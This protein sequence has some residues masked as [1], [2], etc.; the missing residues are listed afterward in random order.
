M[1]YV[2]TRNRQRNYLALRVLEDSLG[3]DGGRFLPVVFPRYPPERICALRGRS[4]G[5]ILAEILGCFF[6]AGVEAR[7]VNFCVGREPLVIRPMDYRV[8][9]A[10]PWHN[11][12]W[13][14]SRAVETLSG[15]LTGR[16]A[17]QSPPTE[18]VE[19]AVRIGVLFALFGMLMGQGLADWD[20]PVDLAVAAGDFVTPMAGWYARKMG[21]PIG[22][23]VCGCNANDALWELLNRGEVKTGGTA[24]ETNT[25]KGDILCPPCLER[26]IHDCYGPG[27]ARRFSDILS[28]GGAYCLPGEDARLGESLYS[29]VIGDRRVERLLDSVSR[30]GAGIL[31]PYGAL[32]YGGLLDYR[33]GTGCVRTAVIFTEESPIRCKETV[34]RAM[35][36]TETE[37]RQRLHIK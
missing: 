20:D 31:S 5:E 36:I 2:T 25:P 33:A 35:G 24:L 17:S 15:R 22:R 8:L 28:M 21:L 3:P 16:P 27:E 37:L 6:P 23:I 9:V 7:D 26:L 4:F 1:L 19:I 32:A 30:R 13:S 18:W 12:G 10:E 34:C 14:L 29:A 11:P